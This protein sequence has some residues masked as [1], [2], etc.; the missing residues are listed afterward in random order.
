VAFTVSAEQIREMAARAPF[1]SVVIPIRQEEKYI[2][3]SI[4]AVLGQEFDGTCEVLVV[5]GMSTD[6]TREIVRAIGARDSR[7][8]LLD[9]PGRIVPTAMNVGILAARGNIIVRID[10]HCRIPRDYIASVLHAFRESGAECVG[11]AMV[12]EGEGYWGRV[13][14]GATSSAF[15]VGG[16]RFHGHGQ[17]R[18]MDT[19]YLGA[20]P[21]QV[22]FDVGLY[23]EEFVRNQDDELNCRVRSQGGKVF[24]TSRIWAAYTCRSTLRALASQ[25]FQYGWWK[26]RLYRKHPHMIRVR[27]MFPSA[28]LLSLILPLVFIGWLGWRVLLL[29]AGVLALHAIFGIVGGIADG[30]APEQVPGGELAFLVLHL[31]YGAGFLLALVTAPFRKSPRSQSQAERER[32]AIEGA[33]DVR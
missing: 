5:D 8:R 22:L 19:V 27:H 11:G 2:A 14:A 21:K 12:A 18:F 7:V 28:F 10:G 24:F 23:D 26:V 17:S 3:A 32:H 1:V 20:Y 25:Y 30:A 9:N 33:D 15:G 4:E 31:S 6:R 29:P 16:V 13:I